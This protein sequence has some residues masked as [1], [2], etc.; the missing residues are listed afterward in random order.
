MGVFTNIEAALHTRLATLGSSPPV[1]WP[2]TNYRPIENTTFIRPTVLPAS[3][4][5]ETLAGMEQHVGIYQVDVFVP[6]EK[7]VATLDSWLDAIQSLFKSNKTLTATD[8]VFVQ[9]VS[10]SPAVRDEAW[11]TGF[12]E[13]NYICYS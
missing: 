6:L 2:N 13:I 4:N 8:V 7:G 9:A 5:L 1:A 11:Y 10:R 3:T 12:V